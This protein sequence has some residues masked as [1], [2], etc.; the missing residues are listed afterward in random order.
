MNN[1]SEASLNLTQ[2]TKTEPYYSFAADFVLPVFACYMIIVAVAIVGNVMVF[3]AVIVDR[4][5]RNNPTTQLLLSL[6]LSDLVSVTIVAP[7]DIDVFFVRGVWVHGELMCTLWSI[8]C[9]TTVPAVIWTLL[10]ISVDRYRS[11]SDPLNRFR[12]SP[13]M[14]HKRAL[15]I[16]L[17]IW[18]YSV[19]FASIPSMGW[20]DA[21]GKSVIH[22]GMCWFPLTRA[23]SLLTNFLNINLPLLVACGIHVKIYCL[24]CERNK[25]SVARRRLAYM[26]EN[27]FYLRNLQA[28]KTVCMFVGA[29]FF[30]WVPYSMYIILLCLCDSCLEVI[31]EEASPLLLMLGYL[32]SALN[33]FLFAL[34]N[35]SFKTVYSKMFKSALLKSTP[36]TR[37]D[38]TLME[39]SFASEIPDL[40]DKDICLQWISIEPQEERSGETVLRDVNM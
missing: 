39:L 9:E 29:F 37:K 15:I 12:L 11:L 13:F 21:P 33:P 36:K 3:Y 10:A 24:A 17:L 5:L 35:K 28:A 1:T 27:K 40:T 32:N 4:K 18:I 14:T 22:E 8:A 20:R 31:P 23:Y 2:I 25:N 6:A 19:L 26:V 16:N 34:R 30:C 7:L 38:S